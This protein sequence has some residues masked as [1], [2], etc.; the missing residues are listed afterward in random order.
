MT[1]HEAFERA[2]SAVLAKLDDSEREMIDTV[3]AGA[4]VNYTALYMTFSFVLGIAAGVAG[5]ALWGS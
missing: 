3:I 5:A 1:E 4:Q 2:W